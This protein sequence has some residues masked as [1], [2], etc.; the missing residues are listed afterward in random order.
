MILSLESKVKLKDNCNSQTLEINIRK[1][2]SIY[3]Y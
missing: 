3:I 2:V 1:Q